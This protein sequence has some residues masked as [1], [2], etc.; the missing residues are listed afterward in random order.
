VATAPLSFPIHRITNE[1]Y[2]RMVDSGALEGVRV[3]LAEGLLIEVSPQSGAHARLIQVLTRLLAGRADLLRVQLPLEVAEGWIPEPDIALAEHE[4]PA[5]HPATA[6]LVVEVAVS[7][8]GYDVSKA[9]VFA[10]AG[11]P[12]YWIIDVPGRQVLAHTG[13]RPGGYAWTPALTGS[14]TLDP[15]VPGT[16][17]FT[18]RGLFTTAFG[19]GA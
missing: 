8:H 13:P 4:D 2:G 15:G 6:L 1:E 7:S 19:E 10:Q 5:T 11:I 12:T 9:R 14:H 17:P 3:E 18:V 16:E